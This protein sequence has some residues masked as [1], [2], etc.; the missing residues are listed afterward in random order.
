MKRTDLEK[1]KGVAIENRMKQSGIPGRYGQ[2]S[3]QVV[4]RRERRDA[5]QALG[6]V[7][8]AVKLNSALIEQI[9]ALHATRGGELNALVAELL[10]AGLEKA[11]K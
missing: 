11:G 10:E 3:S 4:S 6:L 9:R 7:P 8:F 2:Q 1:L 5:D